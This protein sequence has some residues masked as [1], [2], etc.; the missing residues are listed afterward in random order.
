MKFQDLGLL[1]VRLL[2]GGMMLTHGIPKIDR[3]VGE[4]PYN[5]QVLL[6]W[7]QTSVWC[8]SFLQK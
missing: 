3:L 1:L 4:G 7:V 6:D 2:S 5:F 8:S